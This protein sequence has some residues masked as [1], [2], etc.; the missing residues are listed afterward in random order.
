MGE[1]L[2][3]NYE[4]LGRAVDGQY[5]IS[6]VV[7]SAAEGVPIVAFAVPFDTPAGR[8]VF[9]GGFDV[10]RSPLA[11]F[12]RSSI[13]FPLAHA[14]L[15]DASSAVIASAHTSGF[16]E[17][18][19]EHGAQLAEGVQNRTNGHVEVGGADWYVASSAVDGTRWRV[20]LAG[21]AQAL[22]APLAGQHDTVW[23]LVLALAGG[24]LGVVVLVVRLSDATRARRSTAAE[25]SARREVERQLTVARDAALH[26]AEVQSQLVANTSHEIRT[27]LTVI[28][29]MNELLLDTDLD[30]TQRKFAER[31]GR[32][33]AGLL[34]VVNDLLDFAEIDAAGVSLEVSDLE[35]RSVVDEVVALLHNDAQVKGVD[36]LHVCEPGVAHVVGGDRRR[37]QQI[38]MNLVSN[39]IK[40]TD[41][42]S[43]E[44]W[45]GRRSAAGRTWCGSRSSIPELGSPPPIRSAYSSPSS[46]STGRAPDV[47]GELASV[48]QSPRSWPWP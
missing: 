39:A 37:L 18:P 16:T 28:L 44:S 31:V 12:L 48:W 36:L 29:G 11:A 15:I 43:V 9:S 3:S 27:P 20:V 38:L 13:P 7:P 1:D 21:P 5:A 41:A 30:A 4:H 17:L 25:I 32:A 46:R 35:I 2:T 10:P 8:R 24:G 45:P 19:E 26:A 42:G 33:A 22:Y 40:F 34:G 14:D 47:T 6:A 23:L